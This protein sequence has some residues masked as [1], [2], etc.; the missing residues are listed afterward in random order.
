MICPRFR[1]ISAKD[2]NNY[3]HEFFLELFA[4]HHI[5]KDLDDAAPDRPEAWRMVVPVEGSRPFALTY[6]RACRPWDGV[7]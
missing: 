7:R 5:D 1:L 4:Y 3:L 6:K 2:L